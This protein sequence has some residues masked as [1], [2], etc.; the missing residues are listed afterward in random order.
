M[1]RFIRK[2]V[3]EGFD[4]LRQTR[5]YTHTKW[6]EAKEVEGLYN[7]CSENKGADQLRL[8]F[9]VQCMHKADFLMMGLV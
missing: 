5:L 2:P 7:L 3:F 6:L 1:S 8:C 9:H 4:Q